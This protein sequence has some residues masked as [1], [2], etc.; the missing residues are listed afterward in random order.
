MEPRL[1][2]PLD[3][4]ELGAIVTKSITLAPREGNP[5]P[6]IY[7]GPGYVLNSIGIP[8]K[9]YQAYREHYLIPM[10]SL[11][12]RVITSIAGF[13]A[14]EFGELAAR[15]DEEPRVDAI[16][17]NLS[18]PNIE[19]ESIF[20]TDL[21]ATQTIVQTVRRVTR[22]PLIAKLSPN[23]SDIRPFAE[24]ALE[25][26]A[27]ALCIANTFTGMAIDPLHL[28]PRLG[29]GRGGVTSRALLPIVLHHVWRAYEALRAPIVASGGIFTPDDALQYLLAGAQAIQVGTANF[30]DP[31]AMRSIREGIRSYLATRGIPRLQDLVGQ[32]H[33][34]EGVAG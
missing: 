12:T 27:D 15:L 4:E 34:L 9:G 31:T 16:E 17:I 14:E 32:A 20:A 11:R 21:R 10:A 18:C 30:T 7:E 8:S 23:V 22:K 33:L 29:Y 2:W 3:P 25:S 28:R 6:R 5:P 19:T 24:A 13:T 26:G 1:L